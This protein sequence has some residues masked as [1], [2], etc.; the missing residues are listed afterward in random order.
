V[1]IDR[2]FSPGNL[3]YFTDPGNVIPMAARKKNKLNVSW[4]DIKPFES[5]QKFTCFG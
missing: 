4:I 2:Y 1:V 3:F 5:L